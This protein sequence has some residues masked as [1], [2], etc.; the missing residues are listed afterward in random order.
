MKLT[1]TTQLSLDGVMQGP[2]GP[3]EDTFGDFSRGGWAHFDKESGEFD[4]QVFRRADAFLFGRKT[5]DIFANSWGAMPDPGNSPI[6]VALHSRPKYVVSGTLRNPTWANTKVLSGDFAAAVG[7]LRAQPGGEL[8]VHGSG[9]LIHWLLENS[10]VDE[11]NLIIFPVIL[12]QGIRL[13]PATGPDTALELVESSAKPN[14]VT[15]QV[16]RLN[17]CPKYSTE[18]KAQVR[19]SF[20]QDG[21]KA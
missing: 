10:L 20:E 9:Q 16:Y 15:V 11:M 14:G 19:R 5:Y 8:Q 13:F 4:D 12:G 6:A 3:D 1:T 7:K 18:T 17:G 2:G 21:T